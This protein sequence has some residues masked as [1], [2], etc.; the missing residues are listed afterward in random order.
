MRST[1]DTKT[2]GSIK[3]I[4]QLTCVGP[5]RAMRFRRDTE[6]D[7]VEKLARAEVDELM[8]VWSVGPVVSRR[9]KGSAQGWLAKRKKE[10][11]QLTRDKRVVVVAGQD[12]FESVR[13]DKVEMDLV[14]EALGY[15]GVDLDNTLDIGYITGGDMGGDV[16]SRWH[17]KAWE[18]NRNMKKTSFETDWDKYARFLD[19]M[20]FVD[21]DWQEK[22]EVWEVEDVPA[23]RMPETAKLSSIPFDVT[24]KDEV[25]WWMAPAERTNRMVEW[26]DEVVIV[27]DG[28]Y[29]DSFRRACDYTNTPCTTVFEVTG[30]SG[31]LGMWEPEDDPV[32]FEPDEDEQVTGGRGVASGADLDSDDHFRQVPNDTDE[33]RLN[34][35]RNDISQADPGGSGEGKNKGR[36]G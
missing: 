6:L 2:V 7:N 29:A 24:T 5:V 35:K 9:I 20:R 17:T 8:E 22:H 27:I 15:A 23:G 26:A 10:R 25:E 18:S 21:D 11:E 33:A 32:T 14:G 4:E 30:K 19:P 16:V 13:D 36:W 12:V 1:N 31:K 3:N 28:Q 34:G